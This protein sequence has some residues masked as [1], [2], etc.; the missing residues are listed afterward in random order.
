[1]TKSPKSP[2]SPTA[3]LRWQQDMGADEAVGDTPTGLYNFKSKS[4]KTKPAATIAPLPRAQDARTEP[5]KDASPIEAA[6]LDSAQL[7]RDV[8]NLDDLRK[9]IEAFDG[10]LPLKKTAAHMVVADGNPKAEIMLI[11][12]APGAEEDRLGK[13]FVGAAGQLLDKMLAAIGLDRKTNVYI[14][15]ILFWRP[16]G[17]RTPT[18][19]E[20]ELCLPF[21]KKHIEL[22][23][24]KILV[25]LGGTAMKA[26]FHPKDGIMKLRG[27]WMDF[28]YNED[29]KPIPTL[30]TYH[31]AFLLRTPAH[32]KDS[33]ADLQ[34]LQKKIEEL[35]VRV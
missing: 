13:P 15:N 32:K 3:Q 14:S 29:A 8:K 11:G 24:P 2:H 5:P 31:P 6:M 17:N 35:G 20:M 4:A 30:V 22:I 25:C 18:P 21:V 28:R 9:A 34:D 26:M 19:V 1:M 23:G 27:S 16:P 10:L 33:W 7:L 12:E